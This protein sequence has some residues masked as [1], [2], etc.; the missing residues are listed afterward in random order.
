MKVEVEIEHLVLHGFS[1][2]EGR[3]IGVMIEREM[4][5][6]LVEHGVPESLR[7]EGTVLQ[8]DAGEVVRTPGSSPQQ[9]GR[10]IARQLLTGLELGG[11]FS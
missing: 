11:E 8:L 1:P 5:R 6:L 9:L 3:R 4:G 10:E 2:V 7:Q